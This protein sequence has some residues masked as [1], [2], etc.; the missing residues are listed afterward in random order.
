MSAIVS[1]ITGVYTACFTVCAAA[2]QRRYQSSVLLAFVRGIHR[3]IPLT[4]AGDTI[5]IEK[6]Y[7]WKCRVQNGGHL[8]SASLCLLE[9]GW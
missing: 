1:H 2:D 5:F 3:W 7:I 9:L 8:V 6:I 4:K